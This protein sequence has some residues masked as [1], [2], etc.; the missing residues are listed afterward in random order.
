MNLL[1]RALGSLPLQL[2]LVPVIGI[3]VARVTATPLAG[4]GAAIAAVV[5]VLLAQ[6]A[7]KS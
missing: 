1:S 7:S 3:V 2:A 4:L 5:A 6:R